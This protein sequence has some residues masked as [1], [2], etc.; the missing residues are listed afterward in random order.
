MNVRILILYDLIHMPEDYFCRMNH[1][2]FTTGDGS[3][4]L[5]ITGSEMTYH[6]RSGAIGESLHVFINAG[7]RPLL[8]IEHE[9]HVLEIGFGTGL[10]AL[11]SYV[12]S[13]QSKKLIHYQTIDNF[14]LGPDL[15]E[16]LNYCERLNRPDLIQVF[17]LLHSGQTEGNLM[18]GDYFH[19]EKI[20]CSLLDFSPGKK[21]Q[22]IYFDAFAPDEQPELWTVDV[23]MRLFQCLVPSGLLVTYSAKGQVRRTMQAAGFSVEKLQG[24]FPKKEMIRAVKK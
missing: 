17:G 16:T 18:L 15:V 2:L 8:A 12:E 4:S 23:F 24:Y 1:E 10:N 5:R 13:E 20:Q 14:F 6:S 11:L 7:L 19:F 9:L 22:V 21:F 3:H